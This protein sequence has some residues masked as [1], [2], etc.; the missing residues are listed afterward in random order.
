MGYI[1]MFFI[2]RYMGKEALGVVAF[3]ISFVGLFSFI[4][5]MG[6]DSAHIKRISEGKDLGKCNGT[7][8]SI[9]LFLIFSMVF[10]VLL[11]I[12]LWKNI[13]GHGFESPLHEK[14]IYIAIAYWSAFA[15]VNGFVATF[16]GR[17]E[18]AKSQLIRFT[19][20]VGR[21]TILIIVAL[22]SI[23]VLA[24]VGAYLLGSLLAIFLALALFRRLPLSKPS[25]EYFRSYLRF[26]IPISIASSILVVASNTDVVMIQWFW[27]SSDVADYYTAKKI[28]MLLTMIS[29]AVSTAL[30]PALSSYHSKGDMKMLV[31]KA[32][33]AERYLSMF[34]FPL[35]FFIFVFPERVLVLLSHSVLS[36]A[37]VLRVLVLLYALIVLNYP[38]NNLVAAMDKTIILGKI[39][40]VKALLNIALNLVFIPVSFLGIRMLGMGAFGA[41]LATLMAFL[42][43]TLWLRWD[44]YRLSGIVMDLRVVRH[45]IAAGI[46]SALFYQ[47]RYMWPTNWYFL[48]ILALL[49]LALY[50]LLLYLMR[51]F[52]KEDYDLLMDAI[53][54]K[55]M[56]S[57]IGGEIKGR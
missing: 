3:A 12:Y 6:F 50:F 45:V 48:A 8:F 4:A 23:G 54:P 57:Y 47:L 51:E 14:A 35:A 19:N 22:A 52:R 18:I 32:R 2:I 41:A 44:S 20:D 43:T 38:Y 36:S 9:K 28:A 13:L 11:S 46:S 17:K 42:L 16:N 30:Y 55:K 5:N 26:A 40:I 37:P 1:A 10:T 53:N 7:Y 49:F 33:S 56:I 27:S 24:L 15:L 34:V 25:G 31:E 29:M 39:N 21:S